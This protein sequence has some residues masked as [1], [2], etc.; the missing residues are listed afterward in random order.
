MINIDICEEEIERWEWHYF[1]DIKF[2][3]TQ[4]INKM[5]DGLKSKEEIENDWKEKFLQ[6]SG[7][8]SDFS[9]GAERIYYWLFNQ[10]G[11]P[12]S[13]PIGSD[14]LFETYNAYLHIDIKTAKF[15]N[16]SDFKGR[17]NVGKNQTS[18]SIDNFTSNLP[19]VYTKQKEQKYCLSYTILV[20]YDDTTLNVLAVNLICIPNGKL[21]SIYASNII[22][23]GKNKGNSIRFKYN[24][25]F[26]LIDNTP[27]RY[28]FIYIDK[29]VTENNFL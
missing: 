18:Y 11:K 9:R 1:N 4:D 25:K 27:K 3:L 2:L 6:T 7:T 12:N 10:L 20:I 29:S 21:K 13:T 23:A 28:H 22:D 24:C 19:I 15:S 8:L 26:N 16:K 17:V 14:M 5:I